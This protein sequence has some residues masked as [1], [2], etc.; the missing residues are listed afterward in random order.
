MRR[1]KIVCTLG[2]ASREPA[3]IGHLVEE[4]MNVARI[5]FS[6]GEREEHAQVVSAVRQQAEL[7]GRPVAILQDLQ[8]PKIRVRRFTEGAVELEPGAD[9]C[10]TTRDVPGNDQIVGTTYGGLPLDVK[11][12]DMLLLDD[13][14]LQLEVSEVDNTDVHCRVLVGG[15]L[16]NN[17]GINLP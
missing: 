13:G 9:F 11:C 10:I 16:K 7:R 6:H 4:G 8:G 2:P 14:L 12:G 17:K 3:F 5:N 1:A 15:T